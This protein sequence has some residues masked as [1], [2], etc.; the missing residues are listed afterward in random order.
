MAGD[1]DCNGFFSSSLGICTGFITLSETTDEPTSLLSL[2]FPSA[3]PSVLIRPPTD[4]PKSH[5]NDFP[6][7]QKTIS[8]TGTPTFQPIVQPNLQTISSTDPPTAL[9]TNL[10]QNTTF[11]AFGDVPYTLEEKSVLPNHIK[12]LPADCKFLVHVGDIKGGKTPCTERGYQDIA[13]MLMLSPVPVFIVPGDN[14]W[15]DCEDPDAAWVVWEK[16]FSEFDLKWRHNFGVVRQPGREENFAFVQSGTLFIGL[17][18][19]GGRIH[20]KT[21]W[22]TRLTSQYRWTR[23]MIGNH[24]G[25][26]GATVIF[27]HSH[28]PQKHGRYF[29]SPLK[30]YLKNELGSVMPILYL[31]GDAHRFAYNTGMMGLPTAVQVIVRGG[32]TEPPLKVLVD[33][34]AAGSG[35]SQV[36][37]YDRRLL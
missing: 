8:P 35:A 20:D 15:N 25:G 19:V 10:F 31:Q 32:T 24:L 36:F 6:T 28:Q 33:P 5:P 22:S 14:E 34:Q 17:N 3:H 37:Q 23:D 1:H 13:T 30:S 11:C 4:P 26:I 9:S 2:G 29:F 16:V 7:G 21:E 18:I 12:S 27:G